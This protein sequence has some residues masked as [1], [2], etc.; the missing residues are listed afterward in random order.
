MS[1]EITSL[2][3]GAAL[4]LENRV[5]TGSKTGKTQQLCDFAQKEG[6]LLYAR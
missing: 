2:S 4:D 1:E 6:E 5:K 3:G